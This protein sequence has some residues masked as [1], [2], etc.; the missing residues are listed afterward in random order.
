MVSRQ[1]IAELYDCRVLKRD[2]AGRIELALKV[3]DRPNQVE[4]AD[5]AG[6]VARHAEPEIL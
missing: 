3:E 2:R 6:F 1:Q 5:M 4:R